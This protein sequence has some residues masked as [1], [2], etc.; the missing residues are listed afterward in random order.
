LSLSHAK[1]KP[2]NSDQLFLLPPSIEEFFAAV[3]RVIT[4]A[5]SHHWCEVRRRL[6]LGYQRIECKIFFFS[7]FS[8][9]SK[10]PLPFN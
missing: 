7:G 4:K 2:I 10:F 3:G 1:L 9:Q 5:A 6:V 8:A